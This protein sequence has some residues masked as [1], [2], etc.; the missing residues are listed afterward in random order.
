MLADICNEPCVGLDDVR[1]DIEDY[2]ASL[3]NDLYDDV[4]SY[5]DSGYNEEQAA[6]DDYLASLDDD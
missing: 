5:D 6:F 2:Y 4:Q 1:D 3:D